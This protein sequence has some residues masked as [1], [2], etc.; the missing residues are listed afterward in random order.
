ML[1]EMINTF[2]CV[3]SCRC[4]FLQ[5]VLCTSPWWCLCVGVWERERWS[6]CVCVLHDCGE[7]RSAGRVAE[8]HSEW[9]QINE[10][11][12][13]TSLLLERACTHGTHTDIHAGTHWH[14]LQRLIT[15]TVG[16]WIAPPPIASLCLSLNLTVITSVAETY[17]HSY[18]KGGS[19]GGA[20]NNTANTYTIQCNPVQKACKKIWLLWSLQCRKSPAFGSAPPQPWFFIKKC[21][22][23]TKFPVIYKC[24]NILNIWLEYMTYFES[25]VHKK[26]AQYRYCT[27]LY[28]YNLWSHL[29]LLVQR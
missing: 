27:G 24:I 15:A 8:G 13:P 10:L 28:W 14:T 17:S 6:V 2:K 16:T 19:G 12:T 23:L 18:E 20:G 22:K 9:R 7:Y 29:N 26:L 5:A 1:L 25:D 4:I 3:C 21:N 11:E